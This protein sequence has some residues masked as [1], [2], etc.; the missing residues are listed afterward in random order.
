MDK[1][2]KIYL[3]LL[4]ISLI[5]LYI[6]Y[7]SILTYPTLSLYIGFIAFALGFGLSIFLIYE[8][9]M[10]I[11]KK[12]P[13]NPILLFFPL[14]GALGYSLAKKAV[15]GTTL[16]VLGAK[17]PTAAIYQIIKLLTFQYGTFIETLGAWLGFIIIG[18]SLAL[19]FYAIINASVG[20]IT[21]EKAV[22]IAILSGFGIAAGF[23][24]GH[25]STTAFLYPFT[26]TAGP[27]IYVPVFIITAIIG[28]LSAVAS[29]YLL[30][31]R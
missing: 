13:F 5:L 3:T 23:V 14:I 4:I 22:T 25:L 31:K 26:I 30:N 27:T 7:N 24:T 12:E 8:V 21:S 2:D 11:S 18:A 10:F 28:V 9:A 29:I 20:K 17:G 16:E 1:I 19:V 15:T 6:G